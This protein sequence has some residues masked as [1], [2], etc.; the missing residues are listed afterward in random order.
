MVA[1][2]VFYDDRFP[3]RCNG[4]EAPRQEE[5]WLYSKLAKKHRSYW[6][7]ANGR[8]ALLKT[9]PFGGWSVSIYRI[10]RLRFARLI[11]QKFESEEAAQRW[12]NRVLG[13]Y[14][15]EVAA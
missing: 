11:T 1:L 4:G 9:R 2:N 13:L 7:E 5:V 14:A 12:V 6:L 3:A 8:K 10:D 15:P